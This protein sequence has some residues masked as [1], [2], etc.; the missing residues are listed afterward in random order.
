MANIPALRE[1]IARAIL[2]DLEDRRDIK[3]PL[4]HCRYED[5]EIYQEIKDAIVDAVFAAVEREGYVIA[6]LEGKVR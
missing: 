6:K 3:W 1:P 5:E 4:Q 2:D